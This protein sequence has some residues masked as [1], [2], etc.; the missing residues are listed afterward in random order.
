MCENMLTPTVEPLP[1]RPVSFHFQNIVTIS[2]FIQTLKGVLKTENIYIICSKF[3]C[4]LK[5]HFNISVVLLI[6]CN[7]CFS[8]IQLNW[9]DT[10]I[11]YEL[12]T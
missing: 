10:D 2:L 6:T 7:V 3:K 12:L 9:T 5:T 4:F 1:P 11:C 8:N